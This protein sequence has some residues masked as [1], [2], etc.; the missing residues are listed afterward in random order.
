[1]MIREE[2]SNRQLAKIAEK[3]MRSVKLKYFFSIPKVK[4]NCSS[5]IGIKCYILLTITI[6]LYSVL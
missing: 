1:M 2:R 4:V 6:L 5:N 3:Y